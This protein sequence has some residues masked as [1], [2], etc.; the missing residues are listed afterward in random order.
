M[1]ICE[2]SEYVV[3]PE[4]ATSRPA[5]R[6]KERLRPETSESFPASLSANAQP[7]ALPYSWPG[8]AGPTDPPRPYPAASA[9]P[10]PHRWGRARGPDHSAM[11]R[12]RLAFPEQLP[13]PIQKRCATGN[14]AFRRPPPR[15]LF[16]RHHNQERPLASEPLPMSGS[17]ARPPRF[18]ERHRPQTEPPPTDMRAILPNPSQP[19]ARRLRCWP[20]AESHSV[21]RD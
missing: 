8:T 19:L 21:T 9:P 1:L 6:E 20:G 5:G 13:P 18:V 11:R 7:S 3:S 2:R 4:L 16:E 12:A 15:L 17:L 10:S 14:A